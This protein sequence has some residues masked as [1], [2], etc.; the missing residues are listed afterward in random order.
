MTEKIEWYKEVLELEPNSKVFFPLA[1][2]LAEEQRFDEALDVLEHGLERHSE[3][4]EARLLFIEILHQMGRSQACARQIERL[5]G[6]FST[7]AGFWQAWAACLSATDA[8]PDTASV[9]RFLAAHFMRGSVSLHEVLDRGIASL[10]EET[11]AQAPS[12]A[13]QAQRPDAGTLSGNAA[14]GEGACMPEK[15]MTPNDASLPLQP[16]EAEPQASFA[17]P[18]LSSVPAMDEEDDDHLFEDP[19]NEKFDPAAAMADEED[20]PEALEQSS[21]VEPRGESL[22]SSAPVALPSEEGEESEERFSLRTRS[23][24]EVLAEQG[25]IRGALDIYHELA[26]AAISPEESADLQQRITTLSARLGSVQEVDQQ[27]PPQSEESA[28]GKDKLISMLEALAER[29][30]ARAHS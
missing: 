24:A 5:S 12:L 19:D 20:L 13:A 25:D 4:L 22:R 7:Y 2:M 21:Y 1:R 27:E 30:E 3:F 9:L 29:V 23:M 18:P 26:A 10:L 16:E 11:R 14:S 8:S 17:P 28:S 6:M 15:G